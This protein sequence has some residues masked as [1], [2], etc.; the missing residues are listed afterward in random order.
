MKNVTGIVCMTKN[1]SNKKLNC[2]EINMSRM[3]GLANNPTSINTIK[4]F[5]EL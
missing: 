5:L 4:S 2:P 1:L 3:C